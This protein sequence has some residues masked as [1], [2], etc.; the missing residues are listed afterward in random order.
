MSQGIRF[1]CGCTSGRE[2]SYPLWLYVSGCEGLFLHVCQQCVVSDLCVAVCPRLLGFLL[3]FFVPACA[4][5]E[6]FWVYVS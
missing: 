2:V 1:V 3:S 4:I 5:S 6:V